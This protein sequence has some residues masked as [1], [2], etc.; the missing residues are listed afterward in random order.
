MDEP[1][2]RCPYCAETIHAEAMKCR[3]CRSRLDQGAFARSWYRQGEGKL[4]AGVCTG[5]A[6]EFGL[7]VTVVR[8]AFI[9]ATFFGLWPIPL[10][11][12]LWV[13]MP[14]A[15]RSLPAPQLRSSNRSELAPPR[16]DPKPPAPP[17][18]P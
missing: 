18:Q 17:S 14:M 15:P 16:P 9:I 6:R 4:V 13:I 2:K 3:F 7:S 1:M 11:L 12:A 5:L 10:Y 8:I